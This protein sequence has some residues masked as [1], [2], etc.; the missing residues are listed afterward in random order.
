MSE[1]DE[2]RN[3][4]PESNSSSKARNGKRVTP[5]II[6]VKNN[7]RPVGISITPAEN[8]SGSVSMSS[9]VFGGAKPAA[10]NSAFGFSKKETYEKFLSFFYE[11]MNGEIGR[12]W[13]RSIFLATFLVL[14]FTGYG[15]ALM[16]LLE[17][18]SDKGFGHM[19]NL[20]CVVIA[21][22]GVLFSA[23]WIMMAKGSKAWQEKY[24]RSL[25]VFLENKHD[26]ALDDLKKYGVIHGWLRALVPEKFS[27]W[28]FRL[29]A[30]AYS[31]SKINIVIGVISLVLWGIVGAVHSALAPPISWV[32]IY[33]LAQS[34]T[35]C[36]C[37]PLAFIALSGVTVIFLI[38]CCKSAV[39]QEKQ[40]KDGAEEKNAT[41]ESTSTKKSTSL[42]TP[43]DSDNDQPES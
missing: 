37:Y 15:C 18:D 23:L 32:Q 26:I 13:Q 20:I 21:F 1:N 3:P 42:G 36:I 39:I 29:K 41:S 30:G 25:F 34:R 28:L 38:W 6:S 19:M 16:R 24:E 12:L 43:S 4:L 10:R 33:K 27:N 11:N 2:Q 17:I 22:L 14:I 9:S 8:V 40:K 31:A 7:M 35:G 5:R